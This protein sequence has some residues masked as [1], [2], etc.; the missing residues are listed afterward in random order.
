VTLR[1]PNSTFA[2]GEVSPELYARTDLEKYSSALRRAENVLIR[3][4]GGV[5]NRAGLK[6][7][8]E[9]KDSTAGAVLIPFE[10]NTTQ[11]YILEFGD[12]YMRVIR[13]GGHVVGPA[14]AISGI[15]QANPGVITANG[16]SFT[17]DQEVSFN[18]ILGMLELN[19]RRVKIVYVD[20]NNF[21]LVDLFGVPVDTTN[22]G[23]YTGSG[24]VTPIYEIATPYLIGELHDVV[25]AQDADVMYQTHG[26]HPLQK[27]GRT[28]HAA[29]TY[30]QPDFIPLTLAPTNVVAATKVGTGS[31]TYR[32]KVA[33]ISDATGEES[34]PSPEDDVDNDL[35]TAG[36][37]NQITWDAV[38]G[39]SR[40]I[41]Y[42]ESNGVFGYIGGT[43]D[44]SFI[45]ENIVADLSDTPQKA[46][47]PFAAA[48]DYPVVC[49]FFEQRLLLAGSIN[50]P[51]VVNMSQSTN[52]ENF[53]RSSPAKDNDAIQFR[54]R[55]RKVNPV[56]AA[57]PFEELVVMTSGAEYIV[58]APD[59]PGY[60]TPSN[61]I[62]RPQ[63]YRGSSALQPLIIGSQMLY[64]YNKGGVIRDFGFEFTQDKFAGND[65][66]ILANH[67]FAG[68]T[69]K[70]WAYQQVPDS[71]VWV[72]LDNGQL[73][74]LTYVR[75][76]EVWAWARHDS[77]AATFESVAVVGGTTEDDVYFVVK[78]QVNGQTKRYI[79]KLTSRL[80]PTL[81]DS[82]FVDAGLSYSGTPVANVVGLWHLEGEPLTVL[83]DGNVIAGRTAVAGQF[84]T[85]LSQPASDIH[86]GLGYTALIETLDVD[87]G[88]LRK[89]GTVKG[90]KV[91]V[92]KVTVRVLNSRGLKVA[93]GTGVFQEW[94]QRED[95]DF[96]DPI[97]LYS[98]HM[99]VTVEDDWDTAGRVCVKQDAP[100]PMHITSIV[101]DIVVG[102]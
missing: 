69:L 77:A 42:K 25:Y 100:L 11:N 5:A 75:E 80:F 95:E 52:L 97:A 101:P 54:V 51:G 10:F 1:V 79:E 64:N 68:R 78:R 91:S 62:V 23:A 84:D 63:G 2:T 56:R 65:L 89:L 15:T 85:P 74:S 92:P 32:Y 36:N 9:V 16:H 44:L 76:H 7:I 3:P 94:K 18:S 59:N 8:A 83:A 26:N 82:Y 98:G 58:A 57:V 86:V 70:A 45:D 37:Q 81:E 14:V 50:D 31:T 72:I 93:A 71:I 12:R 30:T 88:L 35:T 28:G 22:Y 67:L 102:E 55:S 40:Y 49:S 24:F 41:V 17:G 34:L 6:F 43:E 21:S 60:L 13:D 29:W 46:T 48:G 20:T 19:S 39:A 4:H 90:R 87:L 61:P 33:T 38:A 47:N 73:L 66:T 27:L 99:D 53:G 96:G